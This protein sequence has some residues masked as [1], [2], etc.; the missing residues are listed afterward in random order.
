M[1]YGADSKTFQSIGMAISTAFEQTLGP[2]NV[3]PNDK[4]SWIVLTRSVGNLIV[5]EYKEIT[6][7]RSGQVYL[8]TDKKWKK[9]YTK[10]T[11]SKLILYRDNSVCISIV[12]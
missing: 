9:Y 12:V 3:K 1:I 7:G 4:E 11:A 5:E 10:L 2:E 8:K 6:Q